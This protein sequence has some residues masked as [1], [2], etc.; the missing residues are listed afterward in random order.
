MPTSERTRKSIIN[1]RVALGYTVMTY[2]LNFISRTIFLIGLGSALLGLNSTLFNI[3]QFLNIAEV[4]IGVAISTTLYKP[5][6]HKDYEAINDIVS[7]QSWLY[8]RIGLW[9]LIGG[10]LIMCFFPKIFHNSGIEMSYIYAAFTILIFNASL[11]Y[12]FNYKQVVLSASQ[13][14]FRIKYSYQSAMVLKVVF[15]MIA[16]YYFNHKYEWWLA[17][18]LVFA[19][20]ASLMLHLMIKKNAP[21]LKVDSHKIAILK[22]K[23]PDILKKIKQLFFH[24]IGGFASQQATP[25]ILYAYTSLSMVTMYFNYQMLVLAGVTL[26]TTV[27]SSMGA[28]VGNLV[29]QGARGKIVKV[30]YELYSIQFFI[31]TVICVCGYYISGPFIDIWIGKEYI[32]PNDIVCLMM[33]LMFLNSIRT[34]IDAFINAYGMFGDIWSP[35][36]EATINIGLAIILGYYYGLFGILLGIIISLVLMTAIWKPLFLFWK[37][38]RKNFW[39]FIR[40]QLINFGCA[41]GA[42]VVTLQIVP[43][44]KAS[45]IQGVSDTILYSIALIAV[46]GFLLFIFMSVFSKGMRTLDKR[47][48]KI[49]LRK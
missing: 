41:I 5:F 46:F 9:I 32:L 34:V 43:E 12:F 22:Q 14:E 37:G 26:I 49:I 1:G 33:L 27:F 8:K 19:I 31:C 39:G 45:E 6:L 44:S 35:M 3:L 10:G 21:Y 23:Y 42:L 24:K 15:Q 38:F 4:G 36:V 16:V 47:I 30:F 28:S 25:L 29:A 20:V 11:W 40:M 2:V 13:D 7:I 48:L 18:E 17:L